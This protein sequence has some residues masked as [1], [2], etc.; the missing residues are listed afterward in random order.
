MVP[1][2]WT[3]LCEIFTNLQKVRA[4]IWSDGPSSKE[5][6]YERNVGKCDCEDVIGKTKFNQ[7]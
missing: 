2:L 3:T 5:N 1:I 7:I 6:N 4:I